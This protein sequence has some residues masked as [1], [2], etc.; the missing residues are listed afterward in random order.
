MSLPTISTP[1]FTAKVPST[2]K[3]VKMRP[4]RIKEES[5][6]MLIR[7]SKDPREIA[8]AMKDIIRVCSF[9]KLDPDALA[10]FDI[11]YLFL[12]LRSKSV[13]EIVELEMRCM[14]EIPPVD[15]GE[16]KRCGGLIPVTIDISKIKVEFDK[17]FKNTFVVDEKKK[18][19]I[20]LRFPTIDMILDVSEDENF[21]NKDLLVGLVDTI[22][23]DDNVWNADE[24]PREELV[25]F[26][27]SI[28]NNVYLEIKEKFFD[29]MPNLTHKIEYTCPK[30]GHKDSYTFEGI[31]DFF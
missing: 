21:T 11:E 8:G 26:I 2:K 16:P 31:V 28:P 18:I 4:F 24:T 12:Q 6:L 9:E 3:P 13:G 22:F 25:E 30:C 20:T 15:E 17:G 7:E 27:E 19:G 10:I 14:N 23:D 29:K 1:T 5:I